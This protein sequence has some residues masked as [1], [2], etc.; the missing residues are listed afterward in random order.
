MSSSTSDKTGSRRVG[1]RPAQRSG[2]SSAAAHRRGIPP[3][4]WIGVAVV[5]GLIILAVI[6]D[7]N[8]APVETAAGASGTDPRY[9]YVIGEPGVGAAAPGFELP[10]TGGG[11]V[12]LDDY[13][14]QSVLLY[15]QEGLMCQPC[16]DQL[17]DVEQRWED[18]AALGVDSIVSV[19]GDPL[20]A[21]G[22]KVEIEGLET[23]LLSDRDLAVSQSYDANRYGMMGG[24][25]NGHSFVL[26]GPDGEIQWRA[27]YG[28]A[29][30]Y[31]MYLPVDTLLADLEAGTATEG[32]GA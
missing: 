30:E 9:P 28:G 10:S 27:D 31:T 29:P 5:A 24:S 4:V 13:Q 18:F 21:L 26:V 11:T 3:A 7:A 6:F 22:Q 17:R 32:A 8:Q 14:N 20:D 25:R 12:A 16:W 19:T 15:F 1:R 2:R 23:P